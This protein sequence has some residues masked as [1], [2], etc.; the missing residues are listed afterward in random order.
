MINEIKMMVSHAYNTGL[1]IG[2]NMMNDQH[3]VLS[4]RGILEMVLG[5]IMVAVLLPIGIKEF[6]ASDLASG[7]G[8]IGTIWRITPVIIV[9]G[10][11]IGLI[12]NAISG[13]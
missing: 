13:T 8:A 6:M 4:V 2:R 7:N 5:L 11:I 1:S 3:G 9:I 10:V 12:G